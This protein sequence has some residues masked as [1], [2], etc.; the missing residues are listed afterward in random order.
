[1]H[2]TRNRDG[3]LVPTRAMPLAIRRAVQRYYPLRREDDA[4]TQ[5]PDRAT[6]ECAHAPGNGTHSRFDVGEALPPAPA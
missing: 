6:V 2:V 3:L 5:E 4:A 1:V